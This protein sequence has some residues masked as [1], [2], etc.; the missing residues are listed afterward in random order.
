MRAANPLLVLALL[1]LGSC[2]TGAPEPPAHRP[3]VILVSIDTLRAD[4]VGSYGYARDTTPFLDRFAREEAILFERAF[5]SCPWT[6]VAHM[7]MLTGLFPAQHGVV[8]AD[9][10]L[11][12]NIPML[13]ER[14]KAAGYQTV[15]LFQ[16]S[17]LHE[18]FGFARGF[19]VFR[20]HGSAE[21]AGEHLR[22]ELAK[23][24]PARPT[25]LFYHLFDV[26]N[27]PMASGEHMIYPSPEPFQ[28][29]FLPGAADKLP[30]VAPD[31]L[32][33][34]ENLLD[35]EQVEALVALYDG[36]IRHVD[37]RLEE[38]FGQLRERG[39]LEDA[40]VIVTADH[41]EALAQ[42]GRLVGHG[43]LAQEGLHVP[44]IVRRPDRAGAG[45]RV[46]E[47]AH[48][49]DIVP[50]VLEAAGL[51]PDAHLPGRSLLEPLPRE[52]PATGFYLE[53]EF[54]VEWPRKLIH[55]DQLGTVAFDLEQ[56]PG[57]LHPK[58]TK[59]PLFSELRAKALPG[60]SFPAPHP[61]EAMPEEERQRL[62]DLGYGGG[63]DE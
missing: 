14:L 10:A 27:G 23:L 15:A 32:W 51:R 33:D 9:L 25:F 38:A 43:E 6:L 57:E 5:T 48:L 12:E 35:P 55:N 39:K 47:L 34:S 19:D 18:R 60:G 20:S 13:A 49:G 26:H 44:L 54:V 17:W 53:N 16:P 52:R 63:D 56:D 37:T 22:E 24:D 61:L 40:L 62:Q 21:E 4:H 2:G 45:T 50:T 1:A 11:S 8:N 58:R 7:T 46:K 31:V 41:G 3:D 42:R 28:D 59:D 36:G 29:L 30:K